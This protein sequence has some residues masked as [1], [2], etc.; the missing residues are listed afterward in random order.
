MIYP[1]FMVAMDRALICQP[2]A[3]IQPGLVVRQ[4]PPVRRSAARQLQHLPGAAGGK[5]L[6]GGHQPE[7]APHGVAAPGGQAHHPQ[8]VGQDQHPHCCW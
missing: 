5:H 8:A 2:S 3:G 6:G 4:E 7:R 1:V